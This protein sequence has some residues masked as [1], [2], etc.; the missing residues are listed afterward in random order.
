LIH[1]I[2]RQDALLAELRELARE[3][4][5]YGPMIPRS[6]GGLGLNLRDGAAVLEELG[7]SH[8]GPWAVHAGAPDETN[9]AMLDKLANAGQRERYLVPLAAGAVR[10]CYAMTEPSPG[11][12]SDPSMLRTTARREGGRWIIDGHKWF[13]SGALGAHFAIVM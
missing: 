6:L 5:V 4:G 13:I 10:S 2:P 7:R 8:V 1:D 9:I 12:G 3:R 11:A